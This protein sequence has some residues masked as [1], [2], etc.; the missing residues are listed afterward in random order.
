MNRR[1]MLLRTGA[2]TLG[3]SLTAWPLATSAGPAGTRKVLFF[4]KSANFEHAV[5]KRKNG[6]PSFVEKVLADLGPRHGIEFTFSKDGSLFTPEYLAGFD[7]CMFFT[8]GDLLSAGKDGN[9][10]MTKAGKA[11]LLEAINQGKGFIG[12]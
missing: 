6:Q 1:E 2:T 11:A 4:S 7:A 8:S 3:L 5:I 12:L 10:P 9:P